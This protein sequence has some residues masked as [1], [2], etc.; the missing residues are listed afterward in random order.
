IEADPSGIG[1]GLTAL[2]IVDL[3]EYVGPGG[4][5]TSHSVGE[6]LRTL[7][8]RPAADSSRR[9]YAEPA[10]DFVTRFRVGLVQCTCPA[11]RIE[12]RQ[13]VMNHLRVAWLEIDR[14]DPFPLGETGWDHEDTELV[15]SLGTQRVGLGDRQLEVGLAERPIRAPRSWTRTVTGIALR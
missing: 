4:K 9:E 3:Q 15:A 10:K 5:I 13:H 12:G 11:S 2:V 8:R 14:R 1:L 7:T 6:G